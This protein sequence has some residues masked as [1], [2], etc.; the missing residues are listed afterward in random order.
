MVTALPNSVAHVVAMYGAWKAGACVL[1]LRWDLPE[2]ER[3]R[4]LEVA[5]PTVVIGDWE[6]VTSAPILHSSVLDASQYSAEPVPDRVPSPGQGHRHIGIDRD[7]EDHR[8]P[9]PGGVRS[10]G[11]PGCSG[12]VPGA[13]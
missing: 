9:R 2:W 4:V 1:P 10:R 8:A 3:E 5:R 12:S 7:T 11:E 13:P 6:G